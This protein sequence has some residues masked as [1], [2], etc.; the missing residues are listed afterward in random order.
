MESN[1]T[2]TWHGTQEVALEFVMLQYYR[3]YVLPFVSGS[4]GDH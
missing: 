4:R 3:F 1:R 2:E